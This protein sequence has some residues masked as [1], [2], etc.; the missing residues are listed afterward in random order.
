MA[1]KQLNEQNFENSVATWVTLIDFWAEWCG[2]C[3]MVL[4][5]MDKLA[6]TMWDK[7]NICK[8]NVDEAPALAQAFRVMSIPCFVVLKDGKMV[9]QFVWVQTLAQLEEKVSKF[10]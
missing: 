5:V 4:P 3:Q 7:A 10:L 6:E 2:P 1:V 9:D 8:V